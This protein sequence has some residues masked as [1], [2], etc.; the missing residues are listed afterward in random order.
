MFWHT[1]F[2][3]KLWQTIRP[4]PLSNVIVSMLKYFLVY[5]DFPSST[6]CFWTS[7][8]CSW[9]RRLC[10]S[11]GRC[12]AHLSSLQRNWSA[13]WEFWCQ[14]VQ[15]QRLVAY[16]ARPQYRSRN[17]AESIDCRTDMRSTRPGASAQGPSEDHFG[18]TRRHRWDSQPISIFDKGL[19]CGMVGM[20]MVVIWH[21]CDLAWL[22]FLERFQWTNITWM[23]LWMGE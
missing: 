14:W 20:A 10:M 8:V 22:N 12:R 23:W 16:H 6:P 2:I 4:Q 9:S 7:Y 18:C 3:N 1:L 17:Q 5:R 19:W 13:F 15:E 11:Q 21:A